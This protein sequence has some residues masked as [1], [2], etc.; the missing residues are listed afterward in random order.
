MKKLVGIIGLILLSIYAYAQV[1]NVKDTAA[2]NKAVQG[3]EGIPSYA[4]IDEFGDTIPLIYF[5]KPV[6]IVAERS[7]KNMFQK[8]RYQRL[9]KNVKAALP[10]ARIA[11][12]KVKEFNYLFMYAKT[13]EQKHAVVK[14]VEREMRKEFEKD[15][16]N[17]TVT[18]GRILLRLIDRETGN[19]SY[20]LVKDLKGATT[21]VFW[22]T[23]AVV[24]GHSLKQEYEAE[25]SDKEVEEIVRLIDQGLI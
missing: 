15:L 1:R 16:K 12:K 3:K 5:R 8:W 24:F 19:T 6:N 11:G 7:H 21:A 14:R 17:L 20:A 10:Y 2:Y 18:Q 23:L 9:V 25:G 4:T 13:E 22:Q